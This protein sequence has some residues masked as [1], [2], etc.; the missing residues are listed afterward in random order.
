MKQISSILIL[1]SVLLLACDNDEN[2][3]SGYLLE[4]IHSPT[5]EQAPFTQMN[6]SIYKTKNDY[7]NNVNA[8]ITG[9]TDAATGTYFIPADQLE[10]NTT[11]YIDW[12]SDDFEINNWAFTVFGSPLTPH[13]F[14]Y[15]DYDPALSFTVVGSNKASDQGTR[16]VFLNGND[17][18][19]QWE[20][21]GATSSGSD[22]WNSLT[23][24]E[25]YI[26]ITLKKDGTGT[27]IEKNESGQDVI[28]PFVFIPK[29][30]ITM[31]TEKSETVGTISLTDLTD[32]VTVVTPN[33]SYTYILKRE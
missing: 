22:I 12:Y 23:D 14:I 3:T 7:T 19:T 30:Q 29:S 4:F 28:K 33:R 27:Y 10:R 17:A 1:L 26:R 6:F 13:E 16:K 24:N 20:A 32:R 31:Q 21:I 9:K 5:S 18:E 8:F 2:T 25:K 15:T 11:Y